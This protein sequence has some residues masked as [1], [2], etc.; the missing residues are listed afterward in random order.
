MDLLL[1]ISTSNCRD[2]ILNPLVNGS[3]MTNYKANLPMHVSKQCDTC[4]TAIPET[5]LS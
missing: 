1:S 2:F 4:L 3:N 5:K